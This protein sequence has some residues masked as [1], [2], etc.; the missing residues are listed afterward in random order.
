MCIKWL[1]FEGRLDRKDGSTT[2]TFQRGARSD[3]GSPARIVARHVPP[4]C[5]KVA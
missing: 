4:L 2:G 1:A 3:G 5:S